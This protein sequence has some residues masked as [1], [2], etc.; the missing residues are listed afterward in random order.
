MAILYFNRQ[1]GIRDNK[2]YINVKSLN[3]IEKYFSKDN[4]IHKCYMG[5]LYVK[6]LDIDCEFKY[7]VYADIFEN[8]ML[9]H[10][11]GF[12]DS[13]LEYKK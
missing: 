9:N 10:F 8:K 5:N 6:V 13:M 11:I 4:W 12:S 7:E 1:I 3:D 2:E